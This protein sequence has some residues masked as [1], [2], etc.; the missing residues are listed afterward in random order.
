MDDVTFTWNLLADIQQM[1]ALP[2][3]VNAFRAGT[4]VAVLAAA[5]GW[6]M[7]TRGQAFAGHT[8]ALVG[9]PG[10]AGAVLLGLPVTAGY[11]AFCAA[12]ALVIGTVGPGRGRA[13]ESA[14]I[15]TVQ[16]FA[17]ACGFL[18]IALYHGFLSGTSA[19]L[20]GSFLGITTEQVRVLAGIAVA[21]LAVLALL[22]RRLLFASVD[23]GVARARGVPVRL[24]DVAFLLLL[25]AAVASSALITGALLVF[26]L[27]VLPAATAQQITARPAIGLALAAVLALVTVWVALTVSF[28]T[29]YPLGFWLTSLAF[30]LYVLAAGSRALAQRLPRRP[31]RSAGSSPRVRPSSPATGGS[32]APGAGS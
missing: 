19:L 11:F 14:L 15:G 16:A 26:A 21:V 30:G 23:P 8:L 13:E 6:F 3:M 1:W 9:F 27:L 17:L 10:A 31:G 18:F 20:F 28:F 4:M 29:P 22:G 2:F 5:I 24:M 7:A 25:A 12:A 32:I